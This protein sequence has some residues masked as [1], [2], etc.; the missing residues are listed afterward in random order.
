MRVCLSSAQHFRPPSPV[1]EVLRML[2]SEFGV[3]IYRLKWRN[4]EN[5]AENYQRKKD[6]LKL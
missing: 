3:L 4:K 6:F 1:E 2:I 5:R